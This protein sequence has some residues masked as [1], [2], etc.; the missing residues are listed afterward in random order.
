MD[1]T[2]VNLME[3][4]TRAQSKAELYRLLTV[5]GNMYLPPQEQATME[6]ISDIAF[7]EKKVSCLSILLVH[8]FTLGSLFR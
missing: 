4:G 1:S 5:E 3:V 7:Q 6:F 8:I 2:N